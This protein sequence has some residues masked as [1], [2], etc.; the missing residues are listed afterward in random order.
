MDPNTWNSLNPQQKQ[1]VLVTAQ[2]QANQQITQKMVETMLTSCFEKC[3]GTS[4]SSS[5]CFAT[6]QRFSNRNIILRL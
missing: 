3:V 5:I 6:A 4:V 2:Q 1:S